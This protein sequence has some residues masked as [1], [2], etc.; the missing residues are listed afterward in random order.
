MPSLSA[1][2]PQRGREALNALFLIGVASLSILL[3]TYQWVELYLL[4]VRGT[5]PLCSFSAT[6]DC[7]G[8]WNSPL[9]HAV[10]QASGLPIAGWGLA[11]SIVVLVLAGMLRYQTTKGTPMNDTVQALRIVTGAGALIALS[12]LGYSFAIQTFCPTCV[13]FYVLVAA[14]AWISYARLSIGAPHWLQATL[15]SGA[16]L[17]VTLSALI[18][19]GLHTPREDLSTARISTVLKEASAKAPVSPLV[20]FLNSLPAGVQQATSDS[21]DVYRKSKPIAV[22]ADAKRTSFG[23]AS[24]P[25]HL[26]EWTDIRCSHCQHLEAALEEIRGITPP[27]TWSEEARHYP[28]DSECNPSIQ[29]S[30]GG[31]SCLAAKVQICLRGT[32][33]FSRVR[34][35]MFKDQASLTINRIW[36][37]AANDDSARRKTLEGCVNSPATASVLKEDIELAEKYQIEG[38]PLVV[39]NG[40]KGT[41]VPAFIFGL[42]MAGGKDTDPGFLVLPAPSAPRL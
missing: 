16:V 38:T 42:I 41:A 1:I 34:S 29:R 6:F 39:I 3:T 35:A 9:A 22:A 40:R 11:W 20:E 14:A 23:P 33:E 28:L 13:L 10:H 21:L 18:Y 31:I 8:V 24:A 32:P 17:I 30:S 2:Q 37:I 4:R 5:A 19:P 7:A 26:I 15:K 36:T 12:L 25:V 27:G